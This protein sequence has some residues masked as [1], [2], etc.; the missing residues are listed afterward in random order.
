MIAHMF[1]YAQVVAVRCS[2]Q[3]EGDEGEASSLR[4]GVIELRLNDPERHRSEASGLPP[5]RA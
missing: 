1:K 4:G 2:R 3:E 5:R